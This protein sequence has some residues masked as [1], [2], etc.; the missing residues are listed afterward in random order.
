MNRKLCLGLLVGLLDV[1]WIGSASGGIF[2]V[3][4]Q[5][6][7]T[8][9]FPLCKRVGATLGLSPVRDKRLDQEHVG[10]YVTPQRGASYLDCV[11]APLGKAIEEALSQYLSRRGVKVILGSQW[12]GKEES[13]KS[14]ETESALM[15]E[16]ERFWTE[17]SDAIGRPKTNTSIYLNVRLGIK[18]EGRVVTRR[19]FTSKAL[20]LYPFPERIEQMVNRTLADLFDSFLSSIM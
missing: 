14:I 6:Q 9:A 2:P 5:Y 3:H 12:D 19:I 1:L 10:R 15:V 8:G 7:R 13:L 18:R 11:P 17:G 16:V 20:I 4:I